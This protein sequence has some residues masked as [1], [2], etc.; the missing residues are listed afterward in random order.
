[1]EENVINNN[2]ILNSTLPKKLQYAYCCSNQ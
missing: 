1:M 2:S